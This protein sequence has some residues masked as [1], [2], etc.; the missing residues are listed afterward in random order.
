VKRNGIVIGTSAAGLVGAGAL[1]LVLGRTNLA[2][3][4][5]ND[6]PE[7][8]LALTGT[9][10]DFPPNSGHPDFLVNPSATPGA[11]SAQNIELNLDGDGK[12][13]YRGGGRRVTKEWEDNG[14]NRDGNNRRKIA[15]CAPPLP[16]DRTGTFG[17][18]DNGGITSRN[19]FAQWF[20]DV[21]GVNMSRLWTITLQWGNDPAF[22]NCY[23]FDTNDFHPIDRQLL[24]NGPDEHNFYFTYEIVCTF[25]YDAA[26]RQ[27]LWFKGDDDTWVFINGRLVIDHGGIASNREQRIDLDRLGL[28]DGQT[29]PLHF[30]LAERY[31]P[32]TQFHLKTNIR[33][34]QPA[35]GNSILAAFD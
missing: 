25:K 17:N 5:S 14:P 32:Q 8:T 31:Q 6:P 15:W 30:F 4:S 34:L 26:A 27:F 7:P 16:D 2:T 21:P 11:R 3:G 24:G 28:T 33:R 1:A 22:G 13:M 18:P 9:I 12:P 35:G 10:R 23:A 20:R 19:T 29:Y